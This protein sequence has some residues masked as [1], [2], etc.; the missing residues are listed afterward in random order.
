MCFLGTNSVCQSW[1]VGAFLLNI[2]CPLFDKLLSKYT[3]L[4]VGLLKVSPDA[5]GGVQTRLIPSDG[6]YTSR[7]KKCLR[8]RLSQQG[9]SMQ[10][11]LSGFHT[12]QRWGHDSGRK[13]CWGCQRER[14]WVWP[15]VHVWN[16]LFSRSETLVMWLR[17]GKVLA[18]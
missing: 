14:G 10:A 2:H 13:I 18:L 4:S 6:K 16:C 12:Q 8:A 9:W 17:V 1:Q 7:F 15:C 3:P 5:L 11:A